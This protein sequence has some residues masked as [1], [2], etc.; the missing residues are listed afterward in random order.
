MKTPSREPVAA[1]KTSIAAASRAAGGVG[2][3]PSTGEIAQRWEIVALVANAAQQQHNGRAYFVSDLHLFASRSMAHLWL[4]AIQRAARDARLFVLGGD[5]F[6][7]RWAHHGSLGY[8]VEAAAVWLA[9]LARACPDCRFEFL[10]GN[11]D[12]HQGFLDRLD[13]VQAEVTNFAW[14]RFYYRRN[15]AIFLHGDVADR[16][17][18]AESL[19]HRRARWLHHK[20]RGPLWRRLYDWAVAGQLHRPLP[21]VVYPRRT[22]ARRILHYL[23]D[24]GQGP[25][26]GVRH[27]YFGHTH[28]E[29]SH[30]RYGGLE[31]HNGG[32]PIKG[33]RFRIVEAMID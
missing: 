23:R 10:L 24:I 29:L 20:Q 19:A 6:D 15:G 5:I 3:E 7:F 2:A 30:Y 16:F 33:T 27:V 1:A 9:E 32:A 13:G 17:S 12:Y 4:E 14:H 18:T 26:A 22:V 25:E 31:F 21:A 28:R 8:A 11:H